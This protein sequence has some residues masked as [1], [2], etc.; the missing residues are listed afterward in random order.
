ML[1]RAVS[2][3]PKYSTERIGEEVRGAGK[4][5][6]SKRMLITGALGGSVS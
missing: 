5:K 2:E 4:G 1:R 3:D 6:Q